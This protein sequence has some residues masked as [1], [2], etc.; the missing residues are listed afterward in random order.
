MEK[1]NKDF[2]EFIQLLEKHQV[3]Y[4]IVGGYA[5][6]FY[7]FPRYTGD[8]DFFVQISPENADKLIRVFNEFGFG[9]IGLSEADFLEEFFVIEIG[10][11]P[12]KIQVLTGI[13]GVEFDDCYG[14]RVEVSYYGQNMKFIDLKRL[15]QNKEASRRGKDLIDIAELKKLL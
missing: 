11:E 1:L 4:L 14:G 5:V 13:D 7:G 15:I 9:E 6:G 2:L 8:I 12:R 3:K 10:R